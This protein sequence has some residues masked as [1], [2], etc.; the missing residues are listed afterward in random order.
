MLREAGLTESCAGIHRT[1]GLYGA[2]RRGKS[3]ASQHD[4]RQIE[5]DDGNTCHI[6]TSYILGG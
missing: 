1:P 6:G 3:R 2:V 4:C 5:R